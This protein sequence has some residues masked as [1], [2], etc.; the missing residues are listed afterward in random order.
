MNKQKSL[1]GEEVFINKTNEAW[2]E[3]WVGMPE[4]IQEDLNPYKSVVI[5]FKNQRDVDLF[6]ELVDQNITR[7]TKSL[8]FPQEKRIKPSSLIWVDNES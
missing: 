5:H 8:W 2:K 3:E 4:F 1:T 6:S 7:L